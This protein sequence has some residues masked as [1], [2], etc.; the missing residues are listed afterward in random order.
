M[1]PKTPAP[2][3]TNGHTRRRSPQPK[4]DLAGPEIQRF[5]TLRELPIGLPDKAKASSCR[6]LNEILADSMVLYA[7]YKKHHWLVAGPDLLPAPPAVRQARRGAE[8]DHRP[9]SPSGSRASAA[10]PSATRVTPPS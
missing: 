10:S 2:S 1:A 3:R 5:D 6:L 4:L 7:L 8:R 9:R